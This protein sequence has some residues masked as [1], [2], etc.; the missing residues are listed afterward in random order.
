MKKSIILFLIFVFTISGLFSISIQKN[1]RY[2]NDS[3]YQLN[4]QFSKNISDYNL[5]ANKENLNI[6]LKDKIYGN[7]N[8][9]FFLPINVKKNRISI[10]LNSKIFRY[11]IKN[12]TERLGFVFYFYVDQMFIL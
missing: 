5:T 1:V 9:N 7:K 10:K 2:Y 4:I 12:R 8:L 11:K 3:K 6:Y